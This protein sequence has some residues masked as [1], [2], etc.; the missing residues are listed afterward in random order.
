MA[1]KK[2]KKKYQ[3]APKEKK[4]GYLAIPFMAIL[5]IV[6]ILIVA[7]VGAYLILII[8]DIAD[9]IPLIIILVMMQKEHKKWLAE[10]NKGYRYYDPDTGEEVDENGNPLPEGGEVPQNPAPVQEPRIQEPDLPE[11]D[12]NGDIE[13]PAPAPATEPAPQPQPQPQAQPQQRAKY[14]APYIDFIRT[15]CPIVGFGLFAIV[16]LLRTIMFIRDMVYYIEHNAFFINHI[17]NAIRII[18]SAILLAVIIISIVKYFKEKRQIEKGFV[19]LLKIAYLSAII[20]IVGLVYQGASFLANIYEIIDW[21]VDGGSASSTI[22]GIFV[23]SFVTIL[24]Y[25]AF[26]IALIVFYGIALKNRVN[27][28][29]NKIF[30]VMP[31]G[32]MFVICIMFMIVTGV[33]M[34]GMAPGFYV[35]ASIIML[36]CAV[37]GIIPFFVPFKDEPLGGEAAV[38]PVAAAPVAAAPVYQEPA[39]EPK[40][41]PQQ[42]QPQKKNNDSGDPEVKSNKKG[43]IIILIVVAALVLCGG[44][45]VGVYFLIKNANNQNH[46]TGPNDDDTSYY[47][48]SSSKSSSKSSSSSSRSSSKS[49]SS[50]AA[51][52]KTPK[53]VMA[54]ICTNIYGSAKYYDDNNSDYNY[55][56]SDQGFITV[57]NWVELDESY[58]R[59]AAE[60]VVG[61]LPSYL[62]NI[63]SLHSG[64]WSDGLSG[65]FQNFTTQDEQVMVEVGSYYDDSGLNCQ[66]LSHFNY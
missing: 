65:Y 59:D 17:L 53:E 25:V 32:I 57:V 41:Q 10:G 47:S 18:G 5:F 39:S 38:A 45:G 8:V 3:Q 16:A 56:Y 19:S 20:G 6:M 63:D 2:L 9:A 34:P 21:I 66:I 15:I 60:F 43:L 23:R 13:E 62:V 37:V 54:D 35:T 29:K 4:L 51:V 28:I 44:G 33:T 27:S 55:W 1:D 58:L 31:F 36:A 30:A 11:P 7:Q 48:S 42:P 52:S 40:P 14:E 12:E 22:V 50:S 61:K 64:T 46:E 26:D 49:S 24:F